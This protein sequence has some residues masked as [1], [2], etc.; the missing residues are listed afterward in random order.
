METAGGVVGVETFW[1]AADMC[2]ADEARVDV[3]EAREKVRPGLE[4]MDMS[5]SRE[6]WRE[7]ECLRAS[8][9]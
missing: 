5:E 7:T 4:E 8:T 6:E 3:D 1:P 9:S 2:E